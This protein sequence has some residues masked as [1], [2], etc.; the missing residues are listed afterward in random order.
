MGIRS[1]RL[2][3]GCVDDIYKLPSVGDALENRLRLIRRTKI[4]TREVTKF[5]SLLEGKCIGQSWDLCGKFSSSWDL[6][7]PSRRVFVMVLKFVEFFLKK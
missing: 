7:S 6:F 5:S 1:R 4:L 2:G 3:S